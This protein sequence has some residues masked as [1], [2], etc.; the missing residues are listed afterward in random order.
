MASQK[1]RSQ[2]GVHWLRRSSVLSTVVAVV[3]VVAA[4]AL[5]GQ[6]ISAAE[7]RPSINQTVP[8]PTPRPQVPAPG[9]DDDDDNDNS[10]SNDNSA[11][12]A[13]SAV[14]EQQ[15]VVTPDPAAAGAG[16]TAVVN[17]VALNVRQGP[18]TSFPVIGKL[19]QG[20]AITVEAR[21]TAGDW[22]LVCCIPGSETRGWVSAGLIV[23]GFGADGVAGLPVSDSPVGASPLAAT[24]AVTTTAASTVTLAPGSQSGTVA[25][26]NLNVR[27]GP[28][29]DAAVIAKLRADDVV[30]VL[31]RNA[32]GDWLYICC[33]GSPAGNGWVSAAFITPAF[34]A[35]DLEEVNAAA[36]PAPAASAGAAPQAAT[37]EAGNGGLSVAIAQQPPFAVQGN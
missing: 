17:V 25:G 18:G 2:A 10:N 8:P 37:G 28:S 33:V 32:A 31:G 4:A 19:A 34:A 5:L 22:W 15:P 1:D 24:P 3:A 14:S 30:S 16:Q 6:P 29:T 36:P 12:S 9:D 20:D 13:G 11:G 35:A 7:A 23:P 26:V 27:S 21:N